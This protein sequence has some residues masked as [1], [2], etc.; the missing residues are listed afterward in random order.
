MT[1]V[2]C[3]RCRDEV[4]V[5]A[6]ASGRALVRCP[7][8]LEE[9]LLAEA[10]ANAPPLLVIIGGEVEQTAIDSTAASGG[11]YQLAVSGFAPG[12]LASSA[13][14]ATPAMLPRPSVKAMP[15][16]RRKEKSPLVLL[17]NYVV[18][19]V[20]GLALGV[21]VLWWIFRQDPLELGPR[22]ARY[23]PRIVPQQFRSKTLL[24]SSP[25]PSANSAPDTVR[26]RGP[27]NRGNKKAITSEPNEAGVELQTPPGPDEPA[28]LPDAALTPATETPNANERSSSNPSNQGD[29][30]QRSEPAIAGFE[31]S[32]AS[33]T[34]AT[35]MPDLK[36]LLPGGT[37]AARSP[38]VDAMPLP[39]PADFAQAVSTALAALDRYERVPKDDGD[40]ARQAFID[41]Y[42]AAGDVGRV[43]SYLNPASP[44]LADSVT[45]MQALLDA[46]SGA[47]GTSRVRP[48][49]FL[50]AQQ[51]PEQRNGQGLL[52]AG[53]VKEI[54]PIGPLFEV[55]LDASTRDAALILPLI[56]TNDPQDLCK[57][58]DELVVVGRVVD[59]P[60]QILPGYDGDQQRVLR[61]GFAVRVPKPG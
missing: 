55:L 32:V 13:V 28:R 42:A 18:G 51:W 3:P 21:L 50:A 12:S 10:L 49:R 37:S 19:G 30:I 2:R 45:K 14:T 44:E 5:P 20:M 34:A 61:V 60:L 52:V 7:L 58:G 41:L 11:E 35:P 33:P 56:S 22:V 40:A 1:I 59:N 29:R 38:H 23:V 31:R 39:T 26:G 48:I 6:K 15:R 9:Y 53:T 47:K 43:F 24:D 16:P 25:G 54:A 36:D 8:C 57:P 46:L 17:V 4:T 27:K